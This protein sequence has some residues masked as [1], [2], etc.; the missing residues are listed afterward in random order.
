MKRWARPLAVIGIGLAGM[1]YACVGEFYD[2]VVFNQAGIDW[3]APPSRITFRTWNEN[4]PR[5]IADY[6]PS[7][8]DWYGD[9][10]QQ[11]R[12]E[13]AKQRVIKALDGGDRSAIARANEAWLKESNGAEETCRMLRDAVNVASGQPTARFAA[14][15]RAVGRAMQSRPDGIASLAKIPKGVAYPHAQYALGHF[16]PVARQKRAAYVEAS[17]VPGARQIPAKVMAARWRMQLALPPTSAGV[18]PNFTEARAA[19]REFEQ[20]LKLPAAARFHWNARAWLARLDFKQRNFHTAALAYARLREQAKSPLD[21]ETATTS[22]R[23][24]LQSLTPAQADRFRAMILADPYALASYLEYRI[25]H[26]NRTDDDYGLAAIPKPRLKP[27]A[28]IAKE[29][30]ARYRRQMPPALRVALAELALLEQNDVE[31]LRLLNGFPAKDK[32]ADLARYLVASANVR[33]GQTSAALRQ[34][35]DFETAFPGSVYTKPVREYR[36]YLHLKAQDYPKALEEFERLKY[37]LDAA[38]VLDVRM[39]TAEVQRL[40]GGK[41]QRLDYRLALGYRQMRE[42]DYDAAIATFIGIPTSARKK[43]AMVD[44]D[45]FRWNADKSSPIDQIPD[46]LKTAQDLRQFTLEVRD[47]STDEAKAKALYA[48][49]SYLYQRRNLLFYNASLWGGARNFMLVDPNRD[50][51]TAVDRQRIETHYLEHECLSHARRICRQIITQYPDTSSAPLAYY[52][53]ATSTRRLAD[54]SPWWREYG[55]KTMYDEAANSLR[56]LYTKYPNHALAKNARKYET[57]FRQEGKQAANAARFVPIV[58]GPKT[59][60][61]SATALR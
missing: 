43:L 30:S 51:T 32:R 29:A 20:I 4:P 39:S 36:A 1:V 58:P 24:S 22:L 23:W 15:F 55:A 52:R 6:P 2:T 34:L 60:S 8:S 53:A 45:D 33:R 31:V 38:Y 21:E 10:Q 16:S 25:H 46:P 13:S 44:T 26:F 18:R 47:A 48:Y 19:A 3:G 14:Y 41:P 17:L 11:Q 9:Y 7:M 54:F 59:R 35:N 40:S 50:V 42:S 49:A 37:R 28:E 12:A 5:R 27:L 57:V 61:I 56:Q